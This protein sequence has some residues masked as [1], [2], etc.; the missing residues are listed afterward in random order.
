[1]TWVTSFVDGGWKHADKPLSSSAES[2]TA[3]PAILAEYITLYVKTGAT[4]SRK[5]AVRVQTPD[6]KYHYSN[7]ASYAKGVIIRA[8]TPRRYS[9]NDLH[10]E[11]VEIAKGNFYP[12]YH[13]GSDSLP[14]WG[15]CWMV[16]DGHK[17]SIAT[18]HWY[19]W[20]TGET[21]RTVWSVVSDFGILGWEDNDRWLEVWDKYGNKAA[22]TLNT[23]D[24]RMHVIAKDRA[25]TAE[26]ETN[27]VHKPGTSV[28]V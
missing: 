8:I 20:P 1:M 19:T 5:L 2:T 9:T 18:R 17:Y 23:N 4:G 25:I 11:E 22:F 13:S 27:G 21:T 10:I 12:P 26:V 3:Y 15:Y 6:Q 28:W 16:K 24:T 7:S 14:G